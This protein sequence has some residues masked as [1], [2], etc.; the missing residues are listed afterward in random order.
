M[1]IT[2]KT[3]ARNGI[4]FSIYQK[5]ILNLEKKNN[6]ERK[7]IFE[8]NKVFIFSHPS[9]DFH[10]QMSTKMWSSKIIAINSLK[11]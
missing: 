10:L 1:T 4:L 11:N 9:L 6:V 3:P 7:K 5:N 8:Q 2:S